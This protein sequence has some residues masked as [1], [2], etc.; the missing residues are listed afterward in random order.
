MEKEKDIKDIVFT[1]E[2]IK[3]YTKWIINKWEKDYICDGEKWYYIN[4][5]RT[6]TWEQLIRKFM[7]K[8]KKT[9]IVEIILKNESKM[10][11]NVNVGDDVADIN[12]EL[13]IEFGN[14]WLRWE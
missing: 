3:E 1:Y 13:N 6:F 7:K 9:L 4:S 5:L 10:S 8:Q 12:N 11:F 2:E 14:E